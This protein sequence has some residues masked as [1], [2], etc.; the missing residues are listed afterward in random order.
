MLE[1]LLIGLLVSRVAL[2]V[3]RDFARDPPLIVERM[4]GVVVGV[5]DQHT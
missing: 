3:I 1:A 4:C 2:S 5:T